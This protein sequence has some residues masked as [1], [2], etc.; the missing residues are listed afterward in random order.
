MLYLFVIIGLMIISM[1]FYMYYHFKVSRETNLVFK[2][3]TSFWFVLLGIVAILIKE[4]KNINLSILML[5]GL[6]CGFLGDA[7]LGLRKTTS[8]S[9]KVFF[10]MGLIVFIIGNIFY[11]R[12]YLTFSAYPKYIYFFIAMVITMILIVVLELTKVKLGYFRIP[13]YIYA[14]VSSFL[15][16]TVVMGMISNASAGMILA[17]LGVIS[18]VTSDLILSYLYFKKINPI[19]FR[20]YKYIN[21]ITYCFGQ[22][23]I[24]FSIYF[25]I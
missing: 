17:L 9:N 1:S 13:N 22:A 3:I 21:I 23:L 12:A 6:L 19:K 10:G 11:S 16:V 15:L 4:D 24:A 14:Y 18:F 2:L 8:E 7:I 20:I 5:I 25:L